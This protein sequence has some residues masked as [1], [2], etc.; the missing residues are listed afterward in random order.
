MRL[1]ASTA[2]WASHFGNTRHFG[3][4]ASHALRERQP[5]GAGWLVV[6]RPTTTGAFH[7]LD[8][9]AIHDAETALEVVDL[10]LEESSHVRSFFY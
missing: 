10:A 4:S 1:V 2:R 3:L 5:S 6:S 8:K 9:V 7:S